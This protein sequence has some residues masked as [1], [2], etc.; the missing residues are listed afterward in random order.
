M[1]NKRY[2]QTTIDSHSDRSSPITSVS[3]HHI[4]NVHGGSIET[5]DMSPIPSPSASAFL[6]TAVTLEGLSR[7]L[8]DLKD[9]SNGDNEELKCCCGSLG[10]CSTW[11]QRD[12]MEEKLKLSGGMCPP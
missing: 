1:S 2:S 7:Q 12:K 11:I 3:D 4:R 8:G 5:L 6:R 9:D 10:G